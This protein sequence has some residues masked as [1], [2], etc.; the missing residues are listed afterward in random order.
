MKKILLVTLLLLLSLTTLAQEKSLKDIV[1]EH[2]L[3]N[4]MRFLMVQ[5][6]GAVTL[7]F[8]ACSDFS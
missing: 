4:G 1:S 8:H 6:D 2:R 7:N 3:E 5:R